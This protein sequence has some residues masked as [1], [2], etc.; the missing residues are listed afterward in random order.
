[1]ERILDH[2]KKLDWGLILIVIIL[3]SFGLVSLYSSSLSRGDFFNFKKQIFFFIVGFFLMIILSFFDWRRFKNDPYLILFLY[4]ISLILLAGL[5]FFAHEIRGVK[6]WY[7]IGPFSFDPIEFLKLT[8]LLLLAKYFSMRHVEMYRV[9]HILISSVYVL[10][11]SVLIFFQPDLGSVLVLFSF[12]VFILLISGIKLKHFLFLCLIFLLMFFIGWNFFLKDYQKERVISFFQPR[13]EPKG[14]SWNREQSKIA[15]GSGGFFGKGI[16]KGTQ[17]KYKFLPESETDFIFAAIAE[18]TGI[19]GIFFLFL[20][21]YLLFLRI[22]KI[23]SLV[24]TNFERLYILG[25]SFLIFVQFFIHIGMN[26]GILP[27][28]GIPLPFVSYGGS[29][30]IFLFIGLGILQN[31]KVNL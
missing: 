13:L 15:I 5:Y 4:F 30:L 7:K 29:S 28:I 16:G 26:L 22:L 1:M 24:K 12:W 20:F 27:I 10:V 17:V 18:E 3:I 8:L 19:L 23:S 31:M 11:P 6:A 14:S 9:R 25:F 21:F 2:L